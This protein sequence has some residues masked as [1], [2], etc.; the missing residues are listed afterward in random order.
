MIYDVYYSL[1]VRFYNQIRY[2]NRRLA[3]LK[4]EIKELVDAYHASA[5]E[6]EYEMLRVEY[7]ENNR[8][9]LK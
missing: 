1:Y 4:N 3:L 2:V 5:R 7:F 9:Q 6:Q 8:R